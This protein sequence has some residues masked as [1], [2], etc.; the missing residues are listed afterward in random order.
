MQQHIQNQIK[1]NA[2]AQKIKWL[3]RNTF[4]KWRINGIGPNRLAQ[5]HPLIFSIL[6]PGRGSLLSFEFLV[7]FSP[8]N[9][10]G[11]L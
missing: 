4:L 9:N 11:K 6:F 8:N 5:L 10:F 2:N 1:D 3:S 7:S